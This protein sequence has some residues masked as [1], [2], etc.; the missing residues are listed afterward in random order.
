MRRFRRGARLLRHRA[1]ARRE[2]QANCKTLIRWCMDSR[3]ERVHVFGEVAVGNAD[4]EIAQVG[5]QI[6]LSYRRPDYGRQRA[7]CGGWAYA[8]FDEPLRRRC[9]L[10]GAPW[11][12][13]ICSA[14]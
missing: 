4:E 13:R 5:S 9:M 2:V 3:H 14:A 6:G 11:R 12:T 10:Q 7:H 8:F 1:S